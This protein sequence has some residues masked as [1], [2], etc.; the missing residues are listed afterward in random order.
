MRKWNNLLQ[1][2]RPVRAG[3]E[4][5]PG[6]DIKARLSGSFAKYTKRYRELYKVRARPKQ[7]IAEVPKRHRERYEDS[8]KGANQ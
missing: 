2:T 4:L 6:S 3:L 8:R 1:I 7:P 5:E